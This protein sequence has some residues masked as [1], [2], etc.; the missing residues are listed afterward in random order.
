MALGTVGAHNI[1]RKFPCKIDEKNLLQVARWISIP[2]TLAACLIASFF[3]LNHS[4]GATGY[5]LIVAFDIMLAGCIAPLF[6]MFYMKDP[7]PNA[8]F[9]SVFL[10]SLVRVILEFTLPKDGF[11]LLPFSGDE[12]LNYGSVSS[13]LFPGWF[14]VP[15]AD[16]WDPSTCEQER[17][18]D[19]TGVDSLVSPVV[20]LVV[21]LAV[22]Y[23]EKSTGANTLGFLP[24]HWMEPVPESPEESDADAADAVKGKAAGEIS[25]ATSASYADVIT[26]DADVDDAVEPPSI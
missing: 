4:L 17:F 26:T 24:K 1:A 18:R 19:F 25:M 16:K 20:S 13:D 9:L 22:H 23:F 3:Q 8:G 7:S 21:F 15:A 2:M 10:G 6:M 12:Y 14:D 5:L 11:M